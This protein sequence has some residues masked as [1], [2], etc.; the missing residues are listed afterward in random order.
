MFNPCCPKCR[1][2]LEKIPGKKHKMK[3][4]WCKKSFQKSDY[5]P[6]GYGRI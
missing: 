1:F 3:C 6:Y 4:P 2:K 5:N